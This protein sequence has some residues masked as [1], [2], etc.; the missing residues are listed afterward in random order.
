M[1]GDWRFATPER[2]DSVCESVISYVSY[3]DQESVLIERV[4]LAATLKLAEAK[5]THELS[6]SELP[7]W[8]IRIQV[9]TLEI[10]AKIAQLCFD[11]IEMLCTREPFTI[12]G[13]NH[14]IWHFSWAISHQYRHGDTAVK[15]S[16]Q[17]AYKGAITRSETLERCNHIAIH[18]IRNDTVV[19]GDIHT[20]AHNRIQQLVVAP[21]NRIPAKLCRQ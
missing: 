17:L 19:M 5:F 11:N 15:A 10:A 4:D 9:V 21:G 7:M 14:A 8:A 3:N 1:T 13:W 20:L 12:I 6:T 16:L 18:H 2:A